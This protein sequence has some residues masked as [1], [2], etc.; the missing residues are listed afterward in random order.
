MRSSSCHRRTVRALAAL[1]ERPQNN[2]RV[3]ADGHLLY[4]DE[5][6]PDSGGDELDAHLARLFGQ[7]TAQRCVCAFG[8]CERVCVARSTHMRLLKS[9]ACKFVSL[10]LHCHKSRCFMLKVEFDIKYVYKYICRRN[11]HQVINLPVV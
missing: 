8:G 9:R 2:L 6:P 1:I 5:R 11:Q 3:F 10:S 4:G 7:Q